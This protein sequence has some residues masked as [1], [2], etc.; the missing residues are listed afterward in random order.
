MNTSLQERLSS[1]VRRD[2]RARERLAADGSLFQG[3][4]PEMRAIHEANAAELDQILR[5]DGWPTAL[6]VGEEGAE[7]AWLIAQH[8]IGLPDFQRR[9]LRAL[10]A[11][12][13]QRRVPAWQPAMLLDRIRVLEGRPQVYGTSFDW[14]DN[15]DMSPFPIEDREEVDQRRA[16]VGLPPLAAAIERHRCQAADEPKPS[17][18]AERKLQMEDWA[19]EVGWR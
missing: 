18:L 9:C 14:D 2:V 11:A 12:A 6:L 15:G 13:S 10:E 5:Q 4:H 17:D 7:A 8:A 3:Y 19:K 1:L 16:T